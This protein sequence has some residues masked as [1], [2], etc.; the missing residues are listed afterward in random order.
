MRTDEVSEWILYHAKSMSGFGVWLSTQ[1]FDH[2]VSLWERPLSGVSIDD[3]REITHRMVAGEIARPFAD[4]TAAVVRR[5]ASKLRDQRQYRDQEEIRSQRGLECGLC[6][7][8]GLV[9]IWHPLV[10]RSII[11]GVDTF[12]HPSTREIFHALNR[13][14]SLKQ[15]TLVCACRCSLGDRFAN[16]T[17]MKHGVPLPAMQRFGESEYHAAVMVRDVGLSAEH[18]IR[19]DVEQWCQSLQ[20]TADNGGF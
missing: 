6:R 11:E 7:A 19:L 3:A 5:E 18:R 9:T 13:D 15:D 14:G 2:I 8:T 20:L 10:V 16:Q 17:R 1:D 12:R 4:D